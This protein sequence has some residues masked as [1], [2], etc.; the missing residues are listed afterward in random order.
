MNEFELYNYFEN[1]RFKKIGNQCRSF[2]YWSFLYDM[3]I[4]DRIDQDSALYDQ[5]RNYTRAETEY[6]ENLKDKINNR[7]IAEILDLSI[8]QE[9]AEDFIFW[10][11]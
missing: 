9:I 10:H 6:S 8:L 7:I 5:L 3:L 4:E 11:N 1:N 2:T